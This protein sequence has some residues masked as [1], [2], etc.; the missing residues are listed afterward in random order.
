MTS[1]VRV[2]VVG[3]GYWGPNLARNFHQ[4][5]EA[6]LA[7]CCD[8]DESK[9]DKM[10]ILYPQARVTTQY[11]EV[12]ADPEVEAVIVATPARTHY[13][14]AR[15]ALLADKHVLVEKPLAMTSREALN[16][17][18]LAKERHRTLMVGHVF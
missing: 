1:P 9:L 11:G 13:E 5:A 6:E 3:C 16:L 12:L 14:L 15:D 2:A 7:V 10:R 4:L 8:L 18:D 17:I